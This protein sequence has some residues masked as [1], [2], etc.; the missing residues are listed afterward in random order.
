MT[1]RRR[2]FAEAHLPG[3]LEL[4]LRDV[5]NPRSLAYQIN[6]L[7]GHTGELPRD[8]GAPGTMDEGQRITALVDA[9]SEA[10]SQATAAAADGQWDAVVTALDALAAGLTYY[11]DDVTHRYFSHTTFRV[12]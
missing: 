10:D 9:L 2:Y 1:Y 5:S 3:V 6:I 8:A 11:S 7:C 12:N 4:L